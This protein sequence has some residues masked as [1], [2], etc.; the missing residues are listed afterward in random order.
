MYWVKANGSQAV[1]LCLFISLLIFGEILCGISSPLASSYAQYEPWS[2]FVTAEES[3]LAANLVSDPTTQTWPWLQY[4]HDCMQDGDFPLWNFRIFS[5]TP[6]IGNRLTGLLNPLV[7][8]PVYFLNSLAALTVIY[9]T[10]YLLAGIFFYLFLREMK[11]S[12]TAGLIG[13]ACFLLQGTYI[14]CGGIPS[15]DHAYFPMCL[16]FLERLLARKDRTG[17]L[18]FVISLYLLS[19]TGYPQCVVYSIYIFIAWVLFTRWDSAANN[20]KRL[21]GLGLIFLLVFMLGAAQHLPTAE[22][23]QQSLR[24]NPEFQSDLNSRSRFE[25]YDSPASL[26]VLYFPKLFGDCTDGLTTG[27]PTQVVAAL[28]HG[29][30]GILPAIGVLF[31]PL[32]WSNRRARFFGIVFLLGCAFIA[33]DGLLILASKILPGLRISRVKPHFMAITA[34]VIASC[35]VL[36]YVIENIRTNATLK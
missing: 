13:S 10:H 35:F 11:L 20:L 1:A 19:V 17:Y 3:K 36:D 29:Y 2:Q 34:M 27:L 14:P 15:T 23:Y 24:S 25:E 32:V 8:I 12:H 33:C 4:A 30:A 22:F 28:N 18:G 7:L 26:A 16:Y 5:G 31:L 6:F 21:F 9:F